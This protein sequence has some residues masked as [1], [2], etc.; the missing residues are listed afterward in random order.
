MKTNKNIYSGTKIFEYLNIQIF[1]FIPG[2]PIDFFLS[3]SNPNWGSNT[4]LPKG[5][6]ELN[7]LPYFHFN[8]INAH[9][10]TAYPTPSS[11]SFF[12]FLLVVLTYFI[13]PYY[14]L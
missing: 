12:L 6:E 1:I 9:P 8:E 10:P 13:F 4:F 2:I 11:F 14:S 3:Q 5:F 7:A